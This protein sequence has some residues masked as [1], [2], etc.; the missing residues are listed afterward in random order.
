MSTIKVHSEFTPPQPIIV[1]GIH[2]ETHETKMIVKGVRVERPNDSVLAPSE[3]G[4][5][6]A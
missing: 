3:K 5:T 1:R 4:S 2:A 6:H